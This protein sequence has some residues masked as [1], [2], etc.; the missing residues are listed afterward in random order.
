MKNTLSK[1][2]VLSAPLLWEVMAIPTFT[3]AL[4]TMVCR[5]ISVQV[6]PSSDAELMK[7]LPLRWIRSHLGSAP[8]TLPS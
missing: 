7:A 2:A 5:L 8:L 6:L 4:I 3:F 1:P